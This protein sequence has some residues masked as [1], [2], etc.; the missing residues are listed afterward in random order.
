MTIAPASLEER[1]F[2]NEVAERIAEIDVK[3]WPFEMVDKD[4]TRRY[5]LTVERGHKRHTIYADVPWHYDSPDDV[6]QRIQDWAARSH[7]EQRWAIGFEE[8]DGGNS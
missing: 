2:A 8:Y 1:A 3:V 4:G 6:V 5:A 7:S